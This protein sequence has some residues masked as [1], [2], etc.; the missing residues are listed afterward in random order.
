MKKIIG[1]II[2]AGHLDIEWYQPLSSYRFW[3][4]EALEDLKVAAKR[5]DF[6]TYVLD[7]QVYPLEEYLEVVPQD[8]A[9]MKKLISDG[10]LAVGPFYT[11]FDEWIPSAENMIRNCLYGKRKALSYGGY[12][13]A[14]YLPDNFGHPRQMPQILNEFGID[15]LM[16][17]RGM[18]EMEGE[19]PDEFIYEGIDGSKVLASHFRESYSGAFDIFNKGNNPIQPREVPYY[20]EYLSYEYHKELAWHDNP[21]KTARNMIENVHRIK[22]RYPS[23]VL[24]LIAGFDHLPPQINIGETVKIANELQDE[25]EFVMGDAE[26]Y[27]RLVQSRIEKP[28]I[29]NMELIGSRYQNIL[30]GAL[31]TRS[32][33]KRQNFA[34]EA[35]LERYAEPLDAIASGYDYPDKPTLLNEAWKY[36]MINSAH[37]SIHGSSTDEVHVE[38]EARY[39]KARQIAAG[40]IHD[41]MA[42]IGKHTVRWWEKSSE[43]SRGMLTYAPVTTEEWQPG[44]VWIPIGEKK[45]QICDQD[46]TIYPTQI[47]EREAIGINGIGKVR[48]DLFPHAP[49]RKV[50][51]LHPGKCMGLSSFATTEEEQEQEV[52]LWANDEYIENEFLKV[53]VEGSSISILDKRS[54]KWYHDLNVLEED[55]DAGDAWDY[56]PTW[57]KGE[58]IRSSES[59]FKSRLIESGAVKAVLEIEGNICVPYELII[60]E[61]SNERVDIPVKYTITLW[62]GIPRVDVKLTL[63]N[64][65]KDHRIRLHIPTG[66]KTDRILSQGHLAIMDRTIERAK[67]MNPWFQPPTQILPCREWV[68]AEDGKH[69]LSIALKGMYDYEAISDETTGEADIYITLL[70]SIGMMGRLHMINRDGGA[71]DAVKTPGAQCLGEHT[72][73]WSYIPYKVSDEEKAPFLSQ[74]Q[75][76]LYSSVTHAIRSASVEE[77]IE[78]VFPAVS[79][80]EKNIQFSA[81]KKCIDRSGYILRFYENQGKKTEL[82]LRIQGFEEAWRSNMD[83]ASLDTL[84]IKDEVLHIEVLPYKAVSIKLK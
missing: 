19:H 27:I 68:A 56:S 23:G 76:F 16:F 62:N 28:T 5:D 61:R 29:Y 54:G 83:E 74:V 4:T 45:I 36:L 78:N 3:T 65:A 22:D 77:E 39:A 14:G 79:W 9:T 1:F 15:S 43:N 67:E 33:L 63:E 53:I 26:E 12:M 51:F 24:A 11:Q 38:M 44:E 32:Y 10:K 17:M 84:E 37:D 73:E 80:E 55:A 25:I 69:G 48:N 31:S 35:L 71:S 66:L 41:A 34:C 75:G 82:D 6:K 50:L 47:L 64:R 42:H 52:K 57:I 58:V 46:G 72:M 18:P 40:V 30:L 70:R 49:Y 21:E 81:F 2:T 59:V 8:E 13:C 60:E 7:G 20:S